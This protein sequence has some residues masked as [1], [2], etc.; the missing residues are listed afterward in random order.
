MSRITIEVLTALA[1]E[2]TRRAGL[3]MESSDASNH[4]K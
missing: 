2:A 1:T 3:D 4:G